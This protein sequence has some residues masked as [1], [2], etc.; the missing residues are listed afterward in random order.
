MICSLCPH[1]PF[2]TAALE[3]RP[4]AAEEHKKPGTSV[5]LERAEVP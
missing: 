4:H 3:K 2:L 1:Y 5:R